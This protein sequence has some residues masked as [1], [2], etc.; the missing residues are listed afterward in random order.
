[1]CFFLF[2][3]TFSALHF[4]LQSTEVGWPRTR[5]QVATERPRLSCIF[6]CKE[7]RRSLVRSSCFCVFSL[8]HPLFV[9]VHPRPQ[10]LSGIRQLDIVVEV[11]TGQLAWGASR[12]GAGVDKYIFFVLFS[13]LFLLLF[14]LSFSLPRGWIRCMRQDKGGQTDRREWHRAQ[15]KT[16]W[17]LRFFSVAFGSKS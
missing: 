4:C 7:T 1:M 13:L 3:A 17:L 16:F 2:S 5:S 9:C 8:L 10:K 12:E 15:G 14:L 11:H 6:W